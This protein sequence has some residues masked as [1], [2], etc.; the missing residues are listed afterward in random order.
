MLDYEATAADGLGGTN[1]QKIARF[2]LPLY[3]GFNGFD[4][5]EKEPLSE[6]STH[7]LKSNS[8][9][10]TSYIYNTIKTAID[11]VSN[12]EVVETNMMTIP[13]IQNADLTSKLIEVC[14]T[15]GDALAII[16]IEGDYKSNYENINET[17]PNINTAI[18]SMKS[19]NMNSSYGC[20]FFPAVLA[21][22][23]SANALVPMPASVVG[24][25]VIGSSEAASELWFAPAGFNRGG[26]S[27]GA[28]G[29]PVV[30]V[31]SK[32][33]SDDRDRLYEVNINPI[34]SFP[35]E[36]IV[37]FGQKTLQAV[38][39]ALDRINVRRLMIYIKKEI[40]RFANI[41]LFDPNV[42]VT[43][44]RFL[45]LATPFLSDIQ[46]RFGITEYRIILDSTTTTPE[47]IDR[48]AVYAKFF[49][50]PARAIEFIALDF[51]ITSAG[52]SFDD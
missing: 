30:G 50:K 47:L 5:T 52:A 40:S 24:L 48:N 4:I 43:W 16:D 8:T 18:M 32:L 25:G 23:N 15:R 33:T 7:S 34:A 49:I 36:G 21:R 10:E 42:E 51:V 19:R 29:F 44:A 13:G 27:G 22:D 20:C 39:S 17:M 45:N 38:P 28:A 1:F 12:P 2:T 37:V 35:A 9:S 6:G 11:S 3:G 46:A 14:E 41:V 26:L 31:K